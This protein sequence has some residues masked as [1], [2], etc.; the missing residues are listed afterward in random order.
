MFAGPDAL[1]GLPCGGS[2]VAR[3]LSDD[4][5]I[6]DRPVF[7]SFGGDSTGA[8]ADADDD[9]GSGGDDGS[10]GVDNPASA[11]KATCAAPAPPNDQDDRMA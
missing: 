2:A 7:R 5:F 11:A 1:R 3:A 4:P 9:A 10:D 6:V 8:A